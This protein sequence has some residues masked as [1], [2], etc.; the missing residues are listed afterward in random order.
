[1][2]PAAFLLVVQG[3]GVGVRDGGHWGGTGEQE[4]PHRTLQPRV[5]VGKRLGSAL[6]EACLR[7]GPWCPRL[8][9]IGPWAKCFL[10][11]LSHAGRTLLPVPR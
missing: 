10:C 3:P 11:A 2:G 1:M 9:S 5:L 6:S 8:A 7:P 4:E